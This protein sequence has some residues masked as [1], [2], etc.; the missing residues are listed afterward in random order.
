LCG[1][2]GVVAPSNFA[3]TAVTTDDTNTNTTD[4][5]DSSR[6]ADATTTG[7]Y[8]LLLGHALHHEPACLSR[9]PLTLLF[10][11]GIDWWCV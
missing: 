4:T 10:T 1:L 2:G 6:S 8:A 9:R 7:R 5:A 11:C 3:T